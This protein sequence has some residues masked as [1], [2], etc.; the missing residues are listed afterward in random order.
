MPG[1]GGGKQKE[2][3]NRYTELCGGGNEYAL[4]L[5]GCV[6]KALGIYSKPLNHKL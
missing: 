2:A 6:C 5:D 1:A 4:E 3:A